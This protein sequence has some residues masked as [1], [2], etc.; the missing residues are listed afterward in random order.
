ML[1]LTLQAALEKDLIATLHLLS[2]PV[3]L[4][5]RRVQWSVASGYVFV[6]DWQPSMNL[7]RATATREK[8]S[9]QTERIEVIPF[10]REEKWFSAHVSQGMHEMDK[11]EV[12]CFRGRQNPCAG[13]LK[14]FLNSGEKLKGGPSGERFEEPEFVYPAGMGVI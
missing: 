8:D 4:N 14:D 12:V 2:F 13:R 7:R 9:N 5:R 10:T 11:C 1:G 6:R 3:P